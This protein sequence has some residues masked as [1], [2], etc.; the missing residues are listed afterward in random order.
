MSKRKVL[1]RIDA[2]HETPPSAVCGRLHVAAPSSDHL[3]SV[4]GG[5]LPPP[6]IRWFTT[7][8]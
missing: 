2:Q 7:P 3:A 6:D 8:R 5:S 1:E 4:G